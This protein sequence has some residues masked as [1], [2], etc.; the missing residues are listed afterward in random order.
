V[1]WTTP[2]VHPSDPDQI[3]IGDNRGKLY[4]LRAGE[5][6]RALSEAETRASFVGPAAA[7]GNN[8]LAAA[9]GASGDSLVIF[10]ANALERVGER[11]MGGRIVWG[12]VASEDQILLQTEEG[13][14]HAVGTDGQPLWSLE[15]PEGELVGQPRSL[16]AGLLVTGAPGWLL[17]IDPQTGEL[18]RRIDIE[19]PLSGTP[20]AT[21]NML[22]VPGGEGVI[23]VTPLDETATPAGTTTT[24]TR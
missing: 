14:L 12:P 22:L 18:L 20:L 13:R 17:V 4:R 6:V 21:G 16:E 23:Y 10:D 9:A 3:L 1:Q 15:L 19:Q 11:M 7:V 8:L 5:Q 2:V 24:S